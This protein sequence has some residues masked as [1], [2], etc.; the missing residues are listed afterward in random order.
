MKRK[1]IN[2]F[3]ID[4][5]PMLSPDQGVIVTTRDDCK[6]YIDIAGYTHRIMNRPNIKTWKFVYSILTKE[7]YSHVRSLLNGKE[8]FKFTFEDED[9]EVKTREAFCEETSACFWSGRSGLYKNLE[10][11]IHEC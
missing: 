5:T 2:D 8:T 11:E 3:L 7:E 9:G 4:F 1:L 6:T 10:F